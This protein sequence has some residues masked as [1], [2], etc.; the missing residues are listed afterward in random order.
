[1]PY[2]YT[3]ANVLRRLY[4]G[5]SL[6]MTSDYTLNLLNFPG[7]YSQPLADTQLV[8][9][10]FFIPLARRLGNTS[11]ILIDNV[12]FGAFKL[13]WDVSCNSQPTQNSFP[14][15]VYTAI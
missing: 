7:A 11:G 10:V 12:N 14:D 8:T 13:A 1:M 4:P 3:S 6:V 9:D 5:H 2:T 15:C